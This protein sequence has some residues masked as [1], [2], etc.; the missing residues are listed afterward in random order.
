MTTRPAAIA[1]VLLSCSVAVHAQDDRVT[2]LVDRAV[3]YVQ[4]YEK[5]FSAVVC[6]ERQ[7]QRLL[8]VDGRERKQR[9]LVSDLLLIKVGD[10]TLSFRDV[11]A[12]D[13]KSVRDRQERL[14]KLF[15]D[16]NGSRTA[17]R[18][19]R[20]I[21]DESTRYNIG[22]ARNLEG[23]MLPLRILQ[24]VAVSGFR[25]AAADQGLSFEEFRSPA[26]V[27]YRN[28][29]QFKDMFLRGRFDIDS[30][31]GRVRG[32]SVTAAN[33]LFE[34]TVDVRYLEDPAIGLLV[35]AGMQEHYR[36]T[37]NPKD[38]RLEVSASYANFRR[39][40]VRVEERIEEPR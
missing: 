29:Q 16:G 30:D 15:L 36:N 21:S 32:A 17:L 38:D 24:P 18:Q 9:V 40:Q 3:R 26:I 4:E 39:F 37:A 11:I 5:Q 10:E 31:S 34:I 12:V 14:R 20:A 13:G 33:R 22:V 1:G 23:L 8:H 25:F 6:E 28:S 19:A 27:R 7:T 2:T 35:P